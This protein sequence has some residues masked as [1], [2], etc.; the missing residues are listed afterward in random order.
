MKTKIIILGLL[1]T[2][3]LVTIPVITVAMTENTPEQTTLNIKATP[4]ETITKATTI[5]ETNTPE[6]ETTEEET[7][8]KQT[9]YI[10]FGYIK[11][12]FSGV[13]EKNFNYKKGLLFTKN[14]EINIKDDSLTT[15]LKINGKT[16][17]EP[18]TP[19]TL[20]INL[21]S[22]L[23]VKTFMTSL[24][25]WTARYQLTVTGIAQGITVTY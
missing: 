6:E 20:Q 17:I 23:G 25:G 13:Y 3:M 21:M 7:P 8:T 11:A 2:L 4:E 18:G 24:T 9:K 22:R 12:T 1:A 15:P 5:Q 14:I 19:V 16:I 10:P